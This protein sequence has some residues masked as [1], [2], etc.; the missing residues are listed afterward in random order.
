M[1]IPNF[2][3][4]YHLP[5][6]VHFATLAEVEERF[7][8]H[9][10]ERER[11]WLLFSRLLERLSDLGISPRAMLI[12][13]SFVTGRQV[14]G[15]VDAAFLYDP[16]EINVRL[17]NC[18]DHDRDGIN[19]FTD[20]NCSTALRGV[21]GAHPLVAKSEGELAAWS[22][23][24]RRGMPGQG[25]RAPD[26]TKDPPWVVRPYEKGIIRINIR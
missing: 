17:A 13:G 3:D 20:P 26:P 4:Q 21:F 8:R 23:L 11:V 7:S 5:P 2:I 22:L 14:P 18:D 15:D 1:P 10:P 24:F 16:Q 19:L 25:L 6:G 12:D 9:T